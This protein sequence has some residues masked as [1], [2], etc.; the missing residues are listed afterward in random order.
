MNNEVSENFIKDLQTLLKMIG[1]YNGKVDGRIGWRTHFSVI[2]YMGTYKAVSGLN[3]PF[4]KG[5][6]FTKKVV[7]YQKCNDLSVD[8][9]FGIETLNS[10]LNNEQFKCANPKAVTHKV[11]LLTNDQAAKVFGAMGENLVRINLPYTMTLSWDLN[12]KINSTLCHEKVADRLV[13]IFTEV[14]DHYGGENL[15]KLGLDKFGGCFN[16][17]KV[18]GGDTYSTHSWGIAVD[19]DPVRNKFKWSSTKANFA[20][21]EY[22]PFWNIVEKNGGISLGRSL[23]FDWM[24]FQFYN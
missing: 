14:R 2:K 21:K 9:I 15:D 6:N 5:M 11:A 24:H 4:I 20:K 16:C 17:R 22:L 3:K 23:N 12:T 10:I 7:D 18:T 8:G 13:K 1:I 19:L